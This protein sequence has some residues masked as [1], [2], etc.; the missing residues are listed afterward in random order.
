MSNTSTSFYDLF[1]HD[2]DSDSD[3]STFNGRLFDTPVRNPA[4]KTKPLPTLTYAERQIRIKNSTKYERNR[5]WYM[6]VYAGTP[7]AGLLDS[8]DWAEKERKRGDQ[9]KSK[10]KEDFDYK[11]NKRSTDAIGMLHVAPWS[12]HDIY[13]T[14]QTEYGP[15]RRTVNLQHLAATQ[16]AMAAQQ[17]E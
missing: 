8:C 6:E 3:D 13:M 1:G 12:P 10:W 2:S 14:I 4:K 16:A 11:N 17:A 15:Q 5:A 9:A 7:E